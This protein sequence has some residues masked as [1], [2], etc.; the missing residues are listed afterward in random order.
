VYCDTFCSCHEVHARKLMWVTDKCYGPNYI[1]CLLYIVCGGGEDGVDG[2][3]T[4][5]PCLLFIKSIGSYQTK[6]GSPDLRSTIFFKTMC[7]KE[8]TFY[9]HPPKERELYFEW[10]DPAIELSFF[11]IMRYYEVKNPLWKYKWFTRHE[12]PS[13]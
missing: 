7:F 13:M 2:H 6:L 4:S 11:K 8:Y 10:R 1:R 5:L 12:S 9:F 3:N